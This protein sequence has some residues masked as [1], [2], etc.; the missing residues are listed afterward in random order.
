VAARESESGTRWTATG[1]SPKGLSG[2]GASTRDCCA[3]PRVSEILRLTPAP[4]AP[5]VG[6]AVGA[7]VPQGA[8]PLRHTLETRIDCC[9]LQRV[10]QVS[11]PL[12]SCP[13]S[14]LLIRLK[15]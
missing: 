11:F 6:C 10:S 9:D 12:E 14:R 8:P 1:S 4:P 7:Q 15:K 13:S 5:H 3:R 2:C